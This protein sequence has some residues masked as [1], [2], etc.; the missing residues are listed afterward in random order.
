VALDVLAFLVGR[1]LNRHA[2][3]DVFWG[4]GSR[5]LYGVF[6]IAH[7]GS[8]HL[9]AGRQRLYQPLHRLVFVALWG[10]RLSFYLARRQRG[11]KEDARYVLIMK[12]ARG[13][14]ETLYALR[15][16]Y[17]LQGLLLWFVSMPLQWIAFHENV[18]GLFAASC[19]SPSASSSSHG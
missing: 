12:G 15:M 3:I 4:A 10:L 1:A 8:S 14:H 18:D 6:R 2:T 19:W 7:A 5:H 13:R 9:A 11:A 17:G 16:I